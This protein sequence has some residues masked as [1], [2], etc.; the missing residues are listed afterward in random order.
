MRTVMAKSRAQRC[1]PEVRERAVRLER[2]QLPHHPS[3]WAAISAIAPKLGG[4]K[5]TL[6]RWLLKAEHDATAG[7]TRGV[8]DRLAALER[9]HRERK[10]A[11]DI[12]RKASACFAAAGCPLREL[13]RLTR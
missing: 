8:R 9:A 12:V 2:E 4:T 13:D 3:P 5:A 1:S 11:T 10:R 6:R 7:P